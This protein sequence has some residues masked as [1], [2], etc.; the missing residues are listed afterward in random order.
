MEFGVSKCKLQVTARPKKILH[1]KG[2][3]ISYMLQHSTKNALKGKPEVTRRV[4]SMSNSY[5]YCKDE[6]IRMQSEELR[7]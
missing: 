2:D 7:V 6:R 3:D 1:T 5:L 4:S